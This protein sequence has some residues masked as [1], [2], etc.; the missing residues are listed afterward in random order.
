VFA[1]GDIASAEQA[2]RVM[3]YTGADGVLIGRAALGAPWLPGDI[4]SALGSDAAPP[5]RTAAQV[6]AIVATHLARM[7]DFYGAE[8]GVRIARKHGKAYL[9]NLGAGGAVIQR[10]NSAQSPG[11]QLDCIARL[12]PFDAQALAA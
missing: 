10:F 3:A 2:R 7:H 12:E 5:A 9:Q 8:Q 4:A 11:D 6:I 1:N